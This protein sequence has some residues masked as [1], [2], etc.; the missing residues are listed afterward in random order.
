[1]LNILIIPLIILI[2]Y[3]YFSDNVINKISFLITSSGYLAL[4]YLSL[5]LLI[6]FLGK[7]NLR[8][9]ARDFGIATF[10]LS[11]IHFLIYI[12][13]N[14]LDLEILLDDFLLR[15]YIITGYFALLL[16]VPM[17]MTSFSYFQRLYP[18][19]RKIHKIV[20]LIYFFILAHI[21]F[22]IKA[23]YLYL[24]IFI[25]LFSITI[26]FKIFKQKEMNE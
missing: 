17:Y 11:L 4:I 3:I 21:Y 5:V 23:D 7:K 1:M 26:I 9:K 8:Y 19:W 12:L 14:S 22:I 25:M 6:P 13:D 15:N 2:S 18:H 10:Y 16:F 24:F 20:Y